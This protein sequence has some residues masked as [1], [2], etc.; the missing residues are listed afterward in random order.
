MAC[1]ALNYVTVLLRVACASVADY[2][3]RL[4]AVALLDSP[5]YMYVSLLSTLC[6]LRPRWFIASYAG[7]LSHCVLRIV[8]PVLSHHNNLFVSLLRISCCHLKVEA[9]ALLLT[10]AS[11]AWVF[12]VVSITFW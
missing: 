6:V 1:K 10:S 9:F 7:C 4:L 3:I 11:V 5:M 8:L 12:L 2:L